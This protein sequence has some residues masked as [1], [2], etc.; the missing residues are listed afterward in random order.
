M[1]GSLLIGIGLGVPYLL[2]ELWR[3]IKPGLKE[4]E[5]RSASG[6][7][8]YSSVL[9]AL[10]V[11]FGYYI[12]LPVSITFLFGFVVSGNI[13]NN[14]SIDN[15]LTF[16]ATLTIGA[17]IIFQLPIVV[18]ILS[19]IS[20][21]TPKFMRSTRR[22]AV[23]IILIIAAVVTPTPDIITMMIVAFPLFILYE[24]SILVSQRVETKRK[25]EEADFNRGA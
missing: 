5:V 8:F 2:F 19:R 24:L 4:V 12:I 15:Y 20:I 6:F 22:Y 1:N 3:F 18:Y 11:L 9:F 7:V 16:I 10:G 25:K 13:V 23:I 21:L 17:G 14:Y